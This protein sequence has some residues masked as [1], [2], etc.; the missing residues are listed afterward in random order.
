MCLE[1]AYRSASVNNDSYLTTAAINPTCYIQTASG[2]TIG[3]K[4]D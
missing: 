4:P 1:P 2:I 3:D